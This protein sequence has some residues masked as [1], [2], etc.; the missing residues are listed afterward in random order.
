[1]D[2]KIAQFRSDL[3]P[4]FSN[5]F[6]T[7]SETFPK[8]FQPENT[9]LEDKKMPKKHIT[10]AVPKSNFRFVKIMFK[11]KTMAFSP[12]AKSKGQVF[13]K[14]LDEF[15]NVTKSYEVASLINRIRQTEDKEERRRLKGLLP[16]R[17][18][19][20]FRFANDHRSQDSILPEEFTFQ[21][22]VDID[23][24]SQVEKALACAYN[25]DKE[26]GGKWKGMLL[27]AEYSA[28]KKL[29]LDIRIPIGMT[30]EEAQRAYTQALGVDFDADCCSPERMIYITD[31]ASQLY[32]SDQWQARLSDEEI[33]LRRKAY[34]ERGLDIDGR[35]INEN[36]NENEN[37]NDDDYSDDKGAIYPDEY[38]KIP[39]TMIVEVLVQL[40]GGK[41]AHGSRNRFI[42]AI[43][44][45]LRHVCNDDPKWI[46]KIMPD[47]GENHDR[48][49]KTIESACNRKQQPVMS[50]LMEKTL[51]LCRQRLGLEN[52]EGKDSLMH[53]PQMPSRLPA[54]IRHAISKVPDHCRPALA[55]A[56]FPAWA[57]RMG[58]VKLEYADN[59]EMEATM[60]N[61]LV[62]PM[63]TG[64]SCIKKPIDVCLKDIIA[65]DNESRAREQQWK[66]DQNSKAAN[67]KG[68][69]RPKD[70]CIQVVDSDM[71]NAAFTQRLADAERAG[72]KCLYTRMDE[73]EMLS[74][75]AGGSSKEMVSRIICRNFDTDMYGQERVGA[76]SITARAP[77]RWCWNA[78]TTPA[79]AMR[80]F[81]KNV[82]D[83][84]VSRLNFCTI[85]KIEDDGDIPVY[86]RYDEKY[87]MQMMPYLKLLDAADG[88]I[89]CQQAKKLARDL[90]KLAV[91][92]AVLC[93]D[94]GY[95]IMARR[96]AVIVFRKACILYVMNGYK[97][98]REIEDFCRWSFDYDMWIKMSLFSESLGEDLD[99]EKEVIR[100]GLPNMLDQLQDTFS[101]DD[102][103]HLRII[104]GKK[105]PNPKNQLGQW[106]KRGYIV[107]DESIKK[108]RKTQKYFLSRAA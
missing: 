90:C 82:N 108:Y 43:T 26:E 29:H 30:I 67:R 31:E 97:W 105:D 17:C 74:K 53:E 27:H 50:E 20:Y 47:F 54:P 38:E 59:S 32:T 104:M 65:R 19:H 89:V 62:A 84:T 10:F 68:D 15:V 40:M 70:I 3:F 39:Y 106:K 58:G 102:V 37:V 76:Q 95:R 57:V 9:G 107:W 66:D 61:V 52:E 1:M 36:Q 88:L 23:D 63:A 73:V 83:G 92:R 85:P 42:Y 34:E 44:C 41:P 81:R 11:L 56:I 16:F 6:P 98:S 8:P 99:K 2:L 49:T 75:M 101:R 4:T 79:A 80:Y 22:C 7:F 86:K 71:T 93:D 103:Y 25:L 35:R 78:S 24:A 72:H 77:I 51:K 5:F 33:A 14:S 12:N 13:E 69:D 46:R 87:E 96:A 21:T 94:E 48:V 45:Q 64:K 100:G 55:H 18:P 28:S 60:M 91:D